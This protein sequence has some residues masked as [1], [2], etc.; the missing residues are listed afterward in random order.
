MVLSRCPERKLVYGHPFSF[1]IRGTSPTANLPATPAPA[2]CLG[3][4]RSGCGT[5][6]GSNVYKLRLTR[7]R[8]GDVASDLYSFSNCTTKRSFITEAACQGLSAFITTLNLRT[9]AAIQVT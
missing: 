2:R 6:G 3:L 1:N 7:T 5:C 4:E 8:L 9:E